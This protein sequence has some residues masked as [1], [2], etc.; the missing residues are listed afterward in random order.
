MP[1]FGFAVGDFIAS[2]ELLC[3][4]IKSLRET[5]GAAF[6]FQQLQTELAFL[7][8][9]LS[10]LKIL[11]NVIP[12]AT[13]AQ[14]A[15][16]AK[17]VQGSWS[18]LSALFD[19][20]GKFEKY[21]GESASKGKLPTAAMKARW[22]LFHSHDVTNLHQKIA[23]QLSN[24]NLYLEMQQIKEIKALASDN[25]QALQSIISSLK[26][27]QSRKDT[28]AERA[29]LVEALLSATTKLEQVSKDICSC[30]AGLGPQTARN[31]P[32]QLLQSTYAVHGDDMSAEACPHS[33]SQ[34]AIKHYTKI[35]K[36]LNQLTT[37][38]AILV[39]DLVESIIVGLWVLL[40]EFLRRAFLRFQ[41][42]QHPAMRFEIPVSHI[43]RCIR[44]FD[45][46]GGSHVLEYNMF[47]DWQVFEVHLR[48]Q[49]FNAPGYKKVQRGSK[50]GMSIVITELEIKDRRCPRPNCDGNLSLPAGL[51]PLRSQW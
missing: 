33:G 26:E 39:A 1:A 6:E 17:F 12:N 31:Q 49:F 19:K 36:P 4:V 34:S 2:A 7:S 13:S 47:R 32:P 38:L 29:I 24:L 28:E 21:L 42:L 9:V 22:A 44:F 25:Q 3:S 20:V 11:D 41:T 16:A 14:K 35:D 48:K 10:E 30:N 18:R 8:N 23:E 51:Q 15:S 37:R 40:W 46:L 43:S 50:V 5:D 27:Q 45:A